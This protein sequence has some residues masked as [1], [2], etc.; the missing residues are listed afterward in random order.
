VSGYTA[1]LR[2]QERIGGK[3]LPEHKMLMK[4]RHQPFSVYFKYLAP[5]PDPGREVLFVEGKHNNKMIVHK[6][7]ITRHLFPRL[8]IDPNGPLALAD[9]RHPITEAGLAN[10][11]AKL[12][13]YR[14]LDLN[15]G[16]SR[17]TLD[18]CTDEEGREWLR[19]VHVP[20]KQ[21]PD[22]PFQRVEV[23]YDPATNLPHQIRNFDWVKPDH[24]GELPLAERYTYD[25]LNLTAPLGEID[26]D[27]SNPEYAFKR[28]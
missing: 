9:N 27:T 26:F 14:K 11:T 16:E 21:A 18:R 25:D 8:P 6:N 12:I 3:L 2:K 15:D 5:S 17:C 23:L 4:V 13:G 20:G 10:L 19:S 1:T 7:D 22:R 24:E 28:F